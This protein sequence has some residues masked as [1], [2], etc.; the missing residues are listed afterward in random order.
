MPE[1]YGNDE[2]LTPEFSNSYYRT[3]EEKIRALKNER[4]L[5]I[6]Q[7]NEIQK[8]LNERNQELN[9]L[10]KAPLLVG[11]L[12]EVYD[13]GT[14]LIKSTSGP[15]FMVNFSSSFDKKQLI[16][17][18]QVALNQRTLAIVKVLP[19]SQDPLVRGMEIFEKP[20]ISYGDIGGLDNQIQEVRETVELS[21][22]NAE[23]FEKVGIEA[24]K[25]VLLF[26]PPGSGKTLL[27]KAVAKQTNATFISVVASEFVQKYIGEG[28][29]LIRELFE[30]ARQKTPA[31]IFIDELDAI[32][33]K[34]LDIATSGDREV[35]RTFMQLL[36]E[37]DGFSARGNVKIIGATNRVDI[38]DPALL[39][40]GRFD[41]HIEIELPNQEGRVEIF[42][43][44]T[45][46]MN[47]KD[48]NLELISNSAKDV[49]GADIKAICTEAGMSAIRNNRDYVIQ[50]DFLTGYDK[51]TKAKEKKDAITFSYN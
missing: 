38:L 47:L 36:A 34:R 5:L 10:K 15:T 6:K 11:S 9:R 31:I 26:G 37:M 41:R 12:I 30:F 43:I 24:P 17:G 7:R 19:S 25:G 21:L 32:G 42:K 22:T 48:V 18:A 1:Y 46:K 50:L 8:Q 40:R 51:V 13:N 3:L 39:R 45:R 49:S 14:A 35:Q 27:A 44:H 2:S 29:R 16:A 4:R 20:K 33:S 28:A 23:L